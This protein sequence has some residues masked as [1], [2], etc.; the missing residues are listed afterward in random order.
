V[1]LIGNLLKNKR[2]G[3][4]RLAWNRPNLAGSET[5]DLRSADFGHGQTMPKSTAGKRAGGENRSPELTWTGVP[6]ATTQLLLV[7][8]DIDSPT[9]TPFVHC[10]ALLEPDLRTLPA[11]ALSASS[12][13]AGVRRL[14][15]TMGRGY[16]GPE[17]IKGHGPHRYVFQL[18][19]LTTAITAAAGGAPLETAKLTAVLDAITGPVLAR[20]RLD[21]VYTR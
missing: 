13:F 19:A 12:T 6:E 10:V 14:R 1:S 4:A 11:G 5:L 18:F 9:T 16:R 21:G 17:P 3:E 8:Q 20:G 15:T 7:I 2:A